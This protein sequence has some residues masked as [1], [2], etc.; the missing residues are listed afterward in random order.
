M[1]RFNWRLIKN[2]LLVIF[3]IIGLLTGTYVSIEE[4]TE[5]FINQRIVC[6]NCSLS[7]NLFY[8]EKKKQKIILHL[9]RQTQSI[10]KMT[11]FTKTINSIIAPIQN[12]D[13]TLNVSEREHKFIKIR[14]VIDKVS[15]DKII[16]SLQ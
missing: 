2:I 6:N 13:L 11:I 12:T 3:G 1:G 10:N 16:C 14:S 15:S 4:I 5:T 9:S 7:K 8:F